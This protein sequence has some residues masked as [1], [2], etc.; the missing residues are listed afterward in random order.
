MPSLAER[1]TSL[2]TAV[3]SD[4]KSL[5]ARIA[6]LESALTGK[7]SAADLAALTARV[8]ALEAFT[9]VLPAADEATAQSLSEANQGK[10]YFSTDED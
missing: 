4:V 9:P 6:A 7:A 1:V 8:A 5:F 3:A 10:L 2:A